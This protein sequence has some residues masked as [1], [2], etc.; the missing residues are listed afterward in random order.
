MALDIEVD[1]AKNCLD[2]LVKRGVEILEDKNETRKRFPDFVDE[3]GNLR[4]HLYQ[5]KKETPPARIV[6]L[7]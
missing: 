1:L 4:M 2:R 7:I 3:K 6:Y 5:Y